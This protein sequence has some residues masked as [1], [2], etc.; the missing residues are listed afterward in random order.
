MEE[1][2]TEALFFLIL[3][4][5]VSKM[6]IVNML[7][8]DIAKSHNDTINALLFKSSVIAF[9]MLVVFAFAGTF[10]LQNIFR[11]EINALQLAGGI[12]LA[13]IGLRAL[14]NGIF[15]HV[16]THKGLSDLAI[17]PFASPLI[18]GPATIT[19]TILKASTTSPI[20]VS[21]ALLVAITLNLLLVLASMQLK[22][23][24]DKYN[25][26]GALIRITG[27]FVMA[28]GVH[29]AMTAAHAYLFP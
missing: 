20:F 26:T 1:L 6:A 21:V 9:A 16:D 25:I 22:N 10:L 5:P 18:A 28:I 2:F 13:V 3:I 11:I 23:F 27:L 14:D 7:P 17:V 8:Q 12:V 19:A 24:F 29:M 4:N 15:F